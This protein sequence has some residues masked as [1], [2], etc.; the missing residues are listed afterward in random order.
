MK[1]SVF[2]LYLSEFLSSIKQVYI[3]YKEELVFKEILFSKDFKSNDKIVVSHQPTLFYPGVFIKFV[4]LIKSNFNNKLIVFNDSDKFNIQILDKSIE[5]E[6]AYEKIPFYYLKEFI[7]IIYNFFKDILFN[8]KVYFNKTEFID[9]FSFFIELIHNIDVSNFTKFSDFIYF[10]FLKYFEYFGK[11][12]DIEFDLVSNISKTNEFRSFFY[13]YILNYRDLNRFYNDAVNMLYFNEIKTVRKI[14]D[15]E[16]P[17]WFISEQGFR[18]TLYIDNNRVYF[19][20][21]EEKFYI[22]IKDD[23][24][25]NSIRPKAVL[26]ATFRRLFFSNIDILGIGSSY[27]TFI[28]DYL[29]SHYYL[30]NFGFN[31]KKTDIITA[32]L[33]P[34]NYDFIANYV[35]SLD[36]VLSIVNG[37]L[38]AIDYNI[39]NLFKIFEK[40]SIHFKEIEK[41]LN[42]ELKGLLDKVYFQIDSISKKIPKDLIDYKYDL[43]KKIS[44]PSNRKIKKELTKELQ[45]VNNLV[46]ANL[47]NEVN[48]L[49]ELVLKLNK[50]LF[51]YKVIVGNKLSSR[52]WPFFIF[53]LEDYLKLF[54]N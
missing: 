44:D 23:S 51:D 3:P 18:N 49:K 14:L 20:K 9:N 19:L 28:S 48:L 54:N 15:N 17:F 43:I 47:D 38:S 22:D 7:N 45:K 36:S 16:L 21:N 25:L 10:I 12:V 32:T 1:S 27:Y 8:F 39:E 24:I 50:E 41:F 33:Y 42:N 30:N 26:W 2:D 53:N 46:K 6:F 31:L 29:T 11:N 40:L 37:I 35:S 52:F 5:S 13:D 34:F 4:H